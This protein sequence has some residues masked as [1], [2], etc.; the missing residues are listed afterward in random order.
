MLL[1]S[2]G[3]G[4][5]GFQLSGCPITTL[6]VSCF[7]TLILFPEPQYSPSGYEILQSSSMVNTYLSIYYVYLP[8]L[9][10]LFLR[11][12]VVTRAAILT[13]VPDPPHPLGYILDATGGSTDLSLLQASSNIK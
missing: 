13:H 3:H 5:K 1:F 7:S 2:R 10:F 6:F 12:Q 9:C 8:R 11:T 4:S